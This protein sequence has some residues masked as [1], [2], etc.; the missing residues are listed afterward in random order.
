MALYR[1]GLKERARKTLASAILAF[2]WDAAK[3]TSQ[4]HW[5]CHLLRREAESMI[6]PDLPALLAGKHEPQ[7]REEKVALLGVCQF[8]GRHSTVARLYADL[9]AHEPHLEDDLNAQHRYRAARHA[10]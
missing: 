10:V 3:A 8:K 4:D 1:Q 7:D 9:F 2:D 6:F 5:I